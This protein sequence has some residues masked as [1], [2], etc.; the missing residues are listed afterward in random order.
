MKFGPMFDVAK[1]LACEGKG[2]T[3]I[4]QALFRLKGARVAT[5]A[6]VMRVVE[7]MYPIHD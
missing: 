4:R 3:E 7:G 2:A 6:S 5:I 1:Q